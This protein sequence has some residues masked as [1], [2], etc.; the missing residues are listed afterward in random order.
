M[1]LFNQ[2]DDVIEDLKPNDPDEA[3]KEFL[4]KRFQD[5]P[6]LLNYKNFKFYETVVITINSMINMVSSLNN[7]TLVVQL[8]KELT[9]MNPHLT[10]L[11]M[12][13]V[14]FA[15]IFCIVEPEK[16]KYMTVI[17][18]FLFMFIG[19]GFKMFLN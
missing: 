15:I 12:F 16:L 11:I 2:I 10:K 8:M 18:T 19:K 13:V 5:F 6:A 17:T 4:I 1:S 3:H 7:L 14:Y 9:Q